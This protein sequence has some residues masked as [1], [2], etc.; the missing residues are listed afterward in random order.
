MTYENQNRRYKKVA[1]QK[2]ES[3]AGEY[4]STIYAMW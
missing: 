3:E 4:E 2:N 1:A